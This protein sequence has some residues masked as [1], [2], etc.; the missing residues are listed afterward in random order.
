MDEGLKTK[1]RLN[2]PNASEDDM[3]T[4]LSAEKD[5]LVKI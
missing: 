2:A 4:L 5:R 3:E 1:L